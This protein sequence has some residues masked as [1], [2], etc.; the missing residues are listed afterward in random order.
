MTKRSPAYQ[1]EQQGIDTLAAV[2]WNLP[3]PALYEIMVRH[4]LDPIQKKVFAVMPVHGLRLPES[5]RPPQLPNVHE[6]QTGELPPH[7][8]RDR[9]AGTSATAGSAR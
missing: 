3:V 8:V 7:C 5:S 6:N 9:A 1:L 2:H 4:S